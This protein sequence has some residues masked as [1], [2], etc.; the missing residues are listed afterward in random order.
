MTKMISA[1]EASALTRKGDIS[2]P[3]IWFNNAIKEAA[4]AAKSEIIISIELWRDI[5][6]THEDAI[7]DIM[8]SEGYVIE[9]FYKKSY[10]GKPP[11]S[12]R[13]KMV[14][15]SWQSIPDKFR[16]IEGF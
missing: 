10:I 12:R 14:R 3:V 7:K 16:D 15:I 1:K 6:H 2:T 11:Y 4:K 8:I 5:T 9:Y 13:N